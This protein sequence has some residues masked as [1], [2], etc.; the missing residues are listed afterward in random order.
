MSANQQ[1]GYGV[2]S[3][4]RFVRFDLSDGEGLAT[5][6]ELR[7]EWRHAYFPGVSTGAEWLIYGAC[8]A[9]QHDH[10][11]SDYEIFIVRLK[12]WREA[13]DPV[14]L[15]FNSRTDRWPKLFVADAV[16]ATLKA[17][18]DAAPSAK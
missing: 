13:G 6:K 2:R 11:T 1:Y 12:N 3:A 9:D 16:L 4:G 7:G 14:R 18:A 8:P 5:M 15:T 10:G 17:E